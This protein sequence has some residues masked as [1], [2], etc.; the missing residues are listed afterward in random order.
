[1]ISVVIAS[2][3]GQKYILDQI[4]SILC[5]LNLTDELI[6]SDDN[7]TDDTIKLISQL[8]DSRIKIIYGE[9]KGVS[10]NFENAL[11]QAK[12]ET[13]FLCDQDDFWEKEKVKTVIKHLKINDLVVHNASFVDENLND[14]NKDYFSLRNS[15]TGILKNIAR[16]SFVGCCMAFDKKVLEKA[17][18]FPEKIPMH[19][20]WIGLVALKYFKVSFINECLIKHRRHNNNSSSEFHSGFF[21]MLKWRMNIIMNLIRR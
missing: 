18:P 5:Q 12:G 17:L 15:N 14:L 9:N 4:N 2:F 20:Q 16:N 10:K 8:G 7:S 13:I 11:K 19:D 6:I 1:M 3:N 21:Q